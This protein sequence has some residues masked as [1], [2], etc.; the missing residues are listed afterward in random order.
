M[1]SIEKICSVIKGSFIQF[2]NDYEINYL[3]YDSRKIQQASKCVFFAI[4]SSHNDGHKFIGD[5][6]HKGVRNFVVSSKH[7][8]DN[9]KDSNIIIVQDVIAALQDTARYHREQ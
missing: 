2:H 7:S 1:Y 6:Y 3:V 5:A 4:R 8:Y 9:L